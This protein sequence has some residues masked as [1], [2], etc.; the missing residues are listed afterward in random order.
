LPYLLTEVPQTTD[1]YVII[2]IVAACFT[3]LPLFLNLFALNKVDAATIG[4]IMYINPLLNFTI[5]VTV[6]GEKLSTIQVIGYTT[7]FIAL[8]LFN[9][10]SLAKIFQPSHAKN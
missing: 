10:T 8:V 2:F 9:Y 4:I 7:I 6:F 1:F 3:V 5:A